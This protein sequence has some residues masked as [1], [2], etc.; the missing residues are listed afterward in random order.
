LDL[1]LSNQL[2]VGVKSRLSLNLD[3]YNVLNGNAII[4]ENQTFGATWRRP[5]SVLPGRLIQLSAHLDY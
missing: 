3:F 5:S 1:R 2:K 4:T